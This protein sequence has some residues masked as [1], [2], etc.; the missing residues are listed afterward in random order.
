MIALLLTGMHLLLL[1][2]LLHFFTVG[3]FGIDAL[4]LVT[5]RL[6]SFVDGYI[7]LA[8]PMFVLM[9]ALLDRSGIVHDLFE[10]MKVFGKR[11]FVVAIVLASMSGVIG[12]ETVLL[13]ILSLPKMLRLGYNRK[14]AI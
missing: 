5:S 2:V 10:A 12:G 13:G 7:F 4:P 3:W 9:V 14:L 11:V 6:Y 1:L 8:V